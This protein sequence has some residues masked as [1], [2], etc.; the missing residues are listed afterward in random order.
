MTTP[1]SVIRVLYSHECY[2]LYLKRPMFFF[3]FLCLYD[4][5]PVESRYA[6][7]R[8]MPYGIQP[9]KGEFGK[10]WEIMS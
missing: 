4:P 7:S 1:C 10:S 5:S 9:C 3:Y 8:N 2:K 6:C